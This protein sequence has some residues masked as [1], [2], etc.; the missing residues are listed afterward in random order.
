MLGFLC[1]TVLSD[2]VVV[3]AMMLREEYFCGS[4]QCGNYVTG[5]GVCRQRTNLC[6]DACCVK[7]VNVIDAEV[8]AREECVS[9]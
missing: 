7:P 2:L 8:T 4:S 6:D 3:Y 5:S 9:S 1:T